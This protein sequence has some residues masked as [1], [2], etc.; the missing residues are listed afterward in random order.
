MDDNL[1]FNDD[2]FFDLNF[3]IENYFDYN[4]YKFDNERLDSF[5]SNIYESLPYN[6]NDDIQNFLFILDAINNS[7]ISNEYTLFEKVSHIICIMG[8][9]YKS[10]F[11]RLPIHIKRLLIIEANERYWSKRRNTLF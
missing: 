10:M 9:D 3:D 5:I 8:C 2:D 6:D 7:D 4:D 11:K 1:Y